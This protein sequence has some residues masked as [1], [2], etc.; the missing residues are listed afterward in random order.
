MPDV[1]YGIAVTALTAFVVLDGFDFGAGA[2][3]LFV[4]K[5]DSAPESPTDGDVIDEPRP[6]LPPFFARPN[7]L[8]QLLPVGKISG[9]AKIDAL[10]IK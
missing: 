10:D 7:F 2:L 3:H 4:A 9:D 6:H 1:W 8:T 5:T